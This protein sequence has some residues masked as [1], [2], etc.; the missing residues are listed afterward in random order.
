MVDSDSRP[1]PCAK[2]NGLSRFLELVSR[3][4]FS[5][6]LKCPGRCPERRPGGC[7]LGPPGPL[8]PLDPLGPLARFSTVFLFLRSWCLS[9][10]TRLGLQVLGCG[11]FS[12]G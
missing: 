7:P 4:G 6:V 10:L 1:E 2:R 5:V 11:F 3:M 9:L 12:N 8:G